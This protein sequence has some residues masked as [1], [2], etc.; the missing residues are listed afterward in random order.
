MH[1]ADDRTDLHDIS[2]FS[3][4]RLY[5]NRAGRC[6]DKSA[7]SPKTLRTHLILSASHAAVVEFIVAV[8]PIKGKRKLTGYK[9]P[10][11]RMTLISG[12]KT[13]SG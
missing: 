5:E 4:C 8:L 12:S 7:A 1:R 3:H 10:F 13:T 11:R 9:R 2:P 6:D